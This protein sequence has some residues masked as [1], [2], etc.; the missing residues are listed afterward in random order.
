MQKELNNFLLFFIIKSQNLTVAIRK[1]TY[2][3]I[4]ISICSNNTLIGKNKIILDEK[5]YIINSLLDRMG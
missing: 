2:I 1:K 3:Y 5:A 4:I